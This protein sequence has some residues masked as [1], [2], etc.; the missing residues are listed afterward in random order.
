MGSNDIQDLIALEPIL[1]AGREELEAL[2]FTRLASTLRHA[3]ANNP[4]YQ[5]NFAAASGVDEKRY[6]AGLNYF[7]NG[8][9]A[10]FKTLFYRVDQKGGK[11]G[12]QFTVQLQ[13]FYF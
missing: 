7:L 5:R 2:Q 1:G 3:Y 9:N 6:G 10:N 13:F 8:H 12:N 11:T 4:N